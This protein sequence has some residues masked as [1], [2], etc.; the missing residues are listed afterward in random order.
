MSYGC[1]VEQSILKYGIGDEPLNSGIRKIN[2]MRDLPTGPPAKQD[3]TVLHCTCKQ[4]E[5]ASWINKANLPRDLLAI[6][7]Y[8][9]EQATNYM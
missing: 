7:G 6:H 2:I 8:S 3:S 9:K 5:C 1:G 4:A